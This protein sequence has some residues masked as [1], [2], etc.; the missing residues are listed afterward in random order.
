MVKHRASPAHPENAWLIGPP[1]MEQSGIRHIERLGADMDWTDKERRLGMDRPI[2]RRQFFDGVAVAAGSMAAWHIGAG[3]AEAFTPVEDGTYPPRSSGLQGQTEPT[4]QVMH[5]IRDEA[6]WDSVGAPQDTGEVYDLVVVGAGISGL[7]AA[8]LYR[9]QAGADKRVL[10]IDPLAD[11]GGHAKRNEFTTADG[12]LVIGY[13]GSQSMQ[14]PSYFSAAVNQLLADIGIEAS[15]FSEFYDE[16]WA[17]SRGLGRAVYFAPDIWGTEALVVQTDLAADWV[18]LTP[19]N[20]AAKANLIEL[21]DAPRDYMPGL[22]REE[23][24]TRLAQ[25][26]Y[27]EFLLQH[28]G[29][30]PQ[31]VT[32]FEDTTT[33]YFGVGIDAVTALDARANWNP[34]FDGMDLGDMV[35][36]PENSPSGRLAA[37][38][39]D[40]YIYHFPDGNAG[41]ARALVRAMI[42]AALPGTTMEDLAIAPVAYEQL[43]AADS[44]V[45][46]RLN[47]TVVQVAHDGDP[48]SATSVTV[49]YSDGNALRTV[50][51]GHVVLACW[52]RVIPYI[53][54][55]LPGDQVAALYDQQKVPLMYTNVL[56]RNWQA[57]D[58]LKIDGFNAP[59]T[60]WGGADIDFPV[61]MGDYRFADTP[62]DPIVLH[63]SKAMTDP[64]VPSREQA[65]NGRRILFGIPWED[66]E[67]SIREMLQGALGPSGFDAARDIEAITVNRWAHGYAYEYMRPWDAFWPDG[68]LPIESARR[69][70]GRISIANSDSGAYAYA[71]SA[72]DQAVRAVRDLLGTP[73]GA[74]DYARF[75]GPPLDKLGLG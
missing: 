4:R 38:D 74:P 62:S 50:K 52:H 61:S 56:L 72:I 20:D 24:L 55:E 57:F 63:L 8:Y 10:L 65:L 51:A 58:T 33:G 9:Q 73:D 64:G 68:P 60:F 44:P 69:P 43:D 16:S 7:A 12:R 70:W 49:T 40:P 66:L 48:A 46:V 1:D 53:T 32:Y 6:F 17:D 11:F 59:G 5:A 30:D 35:A 23:K 37:T 67:L 75:P 18:P 3:P 29:A 39:P 21:I 26:T 41:I 28:V 47:Q 54:K 34:G 42:P 27:R 36:R 14:T 19:M 45:R 13:G 15:R 22:T 71:H 31:V 2:S 25:M